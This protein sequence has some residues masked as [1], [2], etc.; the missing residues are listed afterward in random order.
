ML[1]SHSFFSKMVDELV[2]FAEYDPELA[3]GIRWIDFQAQKKG[4]SIYD[5]VFDIL[6]RHDIDQKAKDWL[7]ARS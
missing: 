1:E 6:Y 7:D 2:E 3:E 5:M 4:I